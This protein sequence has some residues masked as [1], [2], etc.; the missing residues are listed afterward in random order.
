MKYVLGQVLENK[1]QIYFSKFN[2]P[3]QEKFHSSDN[4]ILGKSSGEWCAYSNVCDHNG[5]TL[6]VDE[7]SLTATCPIHKWTLNLED[8]L[9]ENGCSKKRLKIIDDTESISVERETHTFYDVDASNLSTEPMAM[10]FNAHASVSTTLGELNIITDPWFVGSCFATGWWHAYPPSEEAVQRLINAHLIYISHN[11]PDHLHLQT[12]NQYV[13]KEKWFLIPNFKSKSV[14]SILRGAGFNNLI[15]ADFLQEVTVTV[16]ESSAKLIILNSGDE[17]EDSSLLLYSRNNK[18][19]FGVDTNMPNKWVLPQVDVLFTQFSSGASGFPVRVENFDQNKKTQIV[20]S[21]KLSILNNY[22]SKMIKVTRPKYVVPY[23]GYFSESAR[24]LDVKRI[25]KKN[26]AEDLIKFIEHEHPSVVGINPLDFSKIILHGD[27]LITELLI[28]DP[29]YFVDAE[30]VSDEVNKF[31]RGVANL[32]IDDLCTVGE[33]F[34]KSTFEDDLTVVFIQTNTDFSKAIGPWLEVNFSGAGR[35]FK[36]KNSEIPRGHTLEDFGIQEH[37][38]KVEILLIRGESLGRVLRRGLP[39]EELSIGFQAKMF[40]FPNVY[41]YSFW[42]HFT[43]TELIKL[44]ALDPEK[45]YE[46]NGS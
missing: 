16:G 5:G 19:L 31:T 4:I 24:D 39:F 40:R 18:V 38:N 42:D 12:L 30:Y 10:I 9:Y 1:K 7:G 44:A 29:L 43:N 15:I 2:K 33:L 26:S 46:A 8:A 35:S 28:E 23:A 22:V 14:E 32:S 20:E 45:S 36:L 3:L 11:H 17:R 13:S 25:N 41:N 21:N 34:I 27:Q 6:L 37:S